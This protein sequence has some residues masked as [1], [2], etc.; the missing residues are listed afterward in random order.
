MSKKVYAGGGLGDLAMLTGK[1]PDIIEKYG[2]I[3]YRH[4]DLYNKDHVRGIQQYTQLLE[5]FDSVD[6][7]VHTKE[8]PFEVKQIEEDA[9][10]IHTCWQPMRYEDAGI[11][12]KD[13]EWVKFRPYPNTILPNFD[14]EALLNISSQFDIVSIDED[15]KIVVLQLHGGRYPSNYPE[16]DGHNTRWLQPEQWEEII[17]GILE[18]RNCLVV[19]TGTYPKM[20]KNK[21]KDNTRIVNLVGRTAVSSLLTL[22]QNCDMYI[23]FFGF[24]GIMSM[25]Y[26]TNTLLIF[27]PFMAD[28]T[29]FNYYVH[30]AWIQSFKIPY[31]M[32]G[33]TGEGIDTDEILR[34][35]KEEING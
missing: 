28:P 15:I 7:K 13:P 25:M 22:I 1:F 2:S 17:Y 6:V 12:E 16:I 19:L 26:K 3:N 31:Y 34:R 9:L 32:K 35:F 4:Y 20:V 5:G 33:Q 14:R 18:N 29:Q 27:E 8:N 24:G 11:Y 21:W 23:G 10:Y 30:P